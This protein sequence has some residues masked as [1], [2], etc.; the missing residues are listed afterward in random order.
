M[1]QGGTLIIE[2][3]NSQ[4]DDNYAA[5][6]EDVRP[7]HYVLLVVS[8]TGTGMAQDVIERAFEPFYT[9]K[10]VGKGS[11]LG[12]SMVYGLVK[13]SGGHIKIYSE[14]GQG[15]TVK[16][17]LPRTSAETAPI[18]T[19]E[20]AEYESFDKKVTILVVE[21]DPGVRQLAVK[22]LHNLGY[23]TV[24]AE[25]ANTALRV[26]DSTPQVVL[27]FTDVVLP[28]GKNGMVL[29]QE[30][31]RRRPDLKVLFTSG[32]AKKVLTQ[33]GILEKDVELISKPY[34]KASLASKLRTI[35]SQ[36]C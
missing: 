21:D 15:T 27:L 32:Y 24:E 17:Y 19:P 36:S 18:E 30:A 34:R 5:A 9:T 25:D 20:T 26:L 10:G 22:M 29:A 28:G 14:L 11:G 6:H 2:T 3:A 31:Q 1:P 4:L 8:D 33:Q 7:G 12:L 23:R 35:L 13:Q 16:V